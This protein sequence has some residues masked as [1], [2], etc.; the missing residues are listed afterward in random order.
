MKNF[1]R[2]IVLD[3]FALA[4]TLSED[5]EKLRVHPASNITPL[6]RDY[7]AKHKARMIEQLHCLAQS[8]TGIVSM[9]FLEPTHVLIKPVLFVIKGQ[10]KTFEAGECVHVFDRASNARAFI[11]CFRPWGHD[12]QWAT[13]KNQE[14][15]YRLAWIGGDVRGITPKKLDLLPYLHAYPE[16]IAA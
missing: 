8:E 15:G 13:L 6:A 1:S 7:I 3:R 11:E 16:Q 4:V 12:D 14:K 5:G 2:S 10:G 9:D